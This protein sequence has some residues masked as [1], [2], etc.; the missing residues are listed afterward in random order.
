[1]GEAKRRKEND[2]NYGKSSPF[3]EI[4]DLTRVSD[5][6]YQFSSKFGTVELV[7]LNPPN[8]QLSERCSM[9]KDCNW[10]SFTLTNQNSGLHF[11]GVF[12]TKPGFSRSAIL[13][14][15]GANNPAIKHQI[16]HKV[17]LKHLNKELVEAT[18]Q[19]KQYAQKTNQD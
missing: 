3:V 12:F 5:V 18:R 9:P 16:K 1:M 14:E 19:I 8:P 2:P 7:R 15:K 11:L 10:S 4:K 17:D 13:K 6:S